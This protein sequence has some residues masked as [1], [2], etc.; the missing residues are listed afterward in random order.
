M[1]RVVKNGENYSLE[2]ENG[3]IFK[4]QR[5][6]EKKSNKWHIKMPLENPSGRQYIRE[7]LFNEKS[8]NG[9]YKFE[10]KTEHREGMGGTSW[11]SRLTEEEAKDL[12]MAEAIIEDIKKKAQVRVMVKGSE[13][14]LMAQI[15]KLQ[16]QLEKARGL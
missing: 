16:R 2:C 11:R 15:E 9:V 8:V 6:Y 10:T 3:E 12:A 5:W 14:D 4:C 7:E 1:N 13:E